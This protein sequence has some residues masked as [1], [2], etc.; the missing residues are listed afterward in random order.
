METRGGVDT[1]AGSALDIFVAHG[2]TW[3]GEK[4]VE[5]TSGQYNVTIITVI[6]KC[7]YC[8]QTLKQWLH[9]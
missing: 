5:M 1:I 2:V 9:L 8:F 7:S 3:M 4:V 6:Y